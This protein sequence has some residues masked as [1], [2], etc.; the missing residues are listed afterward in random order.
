MFFR[1]EIFIFY[2]Y[3]IMNAKLQRIKLLQRKNIKSKKY[4][5][6]EILI[7]N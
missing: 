3:E 2:F 1:F 4:H 6:I 5:Y 7:L